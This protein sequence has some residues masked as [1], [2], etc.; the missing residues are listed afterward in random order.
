MRGMTWTVHAAV[1]V[2]LLTQSVVWAADDGQ[3][4]TGQ[5]LLHSCRGI[6]VGKPVGGTPA[7][8]RCLGYFQG[9][10]DALES[11]KARGAVYCPPPAL[12][13]KEIILFYKSEA[14]IFPDAL[15]S[16]ASDL[17]AG[18]LIKFFPCSGD[19]GRG[20]RR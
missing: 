15:D 6:E 7:D 9:V 17:I 14:G 19:R 11:L 20:A 13:V 1:A 12:T 3:S 5:R 8:S 2:F 16:R 18:M 4:I 10:V